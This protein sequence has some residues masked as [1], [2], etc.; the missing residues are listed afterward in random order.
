MT[1][2]TF[3]RLSARSS[4]L[5]EPTNDFHINIRLHSQKKAK[6][7][8]PKPAKSVSIPKV[9]P[10]TP[11]VNPPTS[12]GICPS[13]K[14]NLAEI[15]DSRKDNAEDASSIAGGEA[16]VQLQANDDTAQPLSIGYLRAA[17]AE[18][19]EFAHLN[20]LEPMDV[21]ATLGS[22]PTDE[23]GQSVQLGFCGAKLIRR[24]K[25]RATFYDHTTK[26]FDES[27]LMAFNLFSGYGF[28]KEQ[29]KEHPIQKGSGVWEDQ[30]DE[31][32]ILLIEDV[33]VV[34]NYRRCGLG[35]LMMKALFEAT[36][37]KVENG[38]FVA[39]AWPDP[40]K[41]DY[42]ES[43]FAATVGNL[44]NIFRPG[45]FSQCD[46][47]S[48]PW[49]R[50][51]RFRRIGN[52]IWFGLVFEE[53]RAARITISAKHDYDPPQFK[54][55][56]LLPGVLQSADEDERFLKVVK[57]LFKNADEKG[58]AATDSEGNSSLHLAAL[59]MFPKSVDWI[60]KQPISERLQRKPNSSENTPLEAL[61]QRLEAM[62][63]RLT[64]GTYTCMTWD[65]FDGHPEVAGMCVRLLK[66]VNEATDT[67]LEHYLFGC[68]CGQ[69]ADG[70]LSPRM[71][72]ALYLAA[73]FKRDYLP[74][75]LRTEGSEC[76]ACFSY[77]PRYFTK[78]AQ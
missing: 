32:D 68:T 40:S 14:S 45:V 15:P 74:E 58:Q 50:S 6:L 5:G 34:E 13:T 60:L 16:R 21:V 11:P 22:A 7:N 38:R 67:P 76:L 8:D 64:C 42:F 25:I 51:F 53:G 73:S 69:C 4:A 24:Q 55:S 49:I 63:T 52:S 59:N 1:Q 31:G 10:P 17:I 29:Y 57:D 48:L 12:P 28:L 30:L 35:T 26:P 3:S 23:I 71:N 9:R 65:S 33:I 62:R 44:G 18:Q 27:T 19:D 66:G 78:W 56:H 37:R 36:R 41:T 54:L 2:Q 46:P 20:W 70:Y 43:V 39:I 75:E 61:L 72:Y 77:L 47:V